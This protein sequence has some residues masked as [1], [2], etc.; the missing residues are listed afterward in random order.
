MLRDHGDSSYL[1][2][3]THKS[4]CSEPSFSTTNK[5]KCFAR[6][7]NTHANETFFATCTKQDCEK[8]LLQIDTCHSLTRQRKALELD[9]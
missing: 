4:K 6:H 8:L 2:R 9:E 3:I 7:V 5:N 1:H